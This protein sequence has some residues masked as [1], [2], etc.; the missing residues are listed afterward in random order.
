MFPFRLKDTNRKIYSSGE[1]S[2]ISESEESIFVN[3]EKKIQKKEV[4][5]EVEVRA[6]YEE[7]GVQYSERPHLVVA[8]K[9]KQPKAQ[10]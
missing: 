5:V 3:K 2:R 7:V 10:E 6:V 4:E 8:Q 9:E 1:I